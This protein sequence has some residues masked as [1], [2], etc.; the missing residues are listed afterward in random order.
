MKLAF[1]LLLFFS[2]AIAVADLSK[3][4]QTGSNPFIGK[5]FYVNPSYQA[6]LATSISSCNPPDCSASTKATLQAMTNVASAYWLDVMAKIRG[7]STKSAEGILIDAASRNPAPLV[8]FI[9]YDLPNRDCHA[10]ASNGEICCNPNS[11]GTCNYDLGGDCAQGLQTYKTQYIDPLA[12]LFAQYQNKVPIVAIIEPDSLQIWQQTWLTLTVATLQHRLP[13][14][15]V[16]HM[17]SIK[18]TH[19][20]PR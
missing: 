20:L 6:E 16:F 9:V 8:V 17:L 2:M 14:L 5:Q 18:S 13:T 15:L 19:L 12:K 7:N 1:L 4:R 10:K 3:F 11:D